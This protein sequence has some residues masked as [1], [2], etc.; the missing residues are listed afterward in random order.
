MVG[1][2]LSLVSLAVAFTVHFTND[3]ADNGVALGPQQVLKFDSVLTNIGGGY[4]AQTG[5]F[6]AP[7][8]GV[9]C[10][11]LSVM[12]TNTHTSVYIAVVK[13]GSILDVVFAEG[14]SDFQDQGSTQVTTHLDSGHQVWA[15]QAGGDAVRGGWWT[16]FTGYMIQA[17]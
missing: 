11:F 2:L 3:A 16:I 13:D 12:S 14:Q 5:I 6:T 17:D 1:I 10:F 7:F 15:R 8:S 9:Y 4:N